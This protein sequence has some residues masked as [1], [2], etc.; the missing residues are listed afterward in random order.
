MMG[1]MLYKRKVCLVSAVRSVM[2]YTND[3]MYVVDKK[4]VSSVCCE[5]CNAIY[6]RRD[7]CCRQERCV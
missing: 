1:C 7:V 3:G 5:E 6:C 2:Q 4:G